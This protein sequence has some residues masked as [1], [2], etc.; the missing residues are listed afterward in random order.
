MR[1]EGVRTPVVFLTDSGTRP[2]ERDAGS[3]FGGDDT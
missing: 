3:R 2:E 1:E